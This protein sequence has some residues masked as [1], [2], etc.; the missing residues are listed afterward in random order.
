MT[1]FCRLS[2]KRLVF[3]VRLGSLRRKYTL[4]FHIPVLYGIVCTNTNSLHSLPLFIG[5]NMVISFLQPVPSDRLMKELRNRAH[6]HAASLII[7]D[8]SQTS[9]QCLKNSCKLQCWLP[10]LFCLLIPYTV[11]IFDYCVCLYQ[12]KSR[13]IST[14]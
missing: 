10:N 3:W 11:C 9:K 12:N 14:S 5:V 7:L 13:Y 1:S 6:H 4:G 8:L 2:V